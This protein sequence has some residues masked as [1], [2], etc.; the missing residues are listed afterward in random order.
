MGKAI[1]GI[2]A[3]YH[4]S[5]AALLV[6]GNISAAIQQERVSRKK[7]DASF[8]L[9]AI[10]QILTE[11]SVG[12][13]ELSAIVFY[14][15][16]FLKFERILETIHMEAP[17]GWAQF[18]AAM[19]EWIDKKLFIKKHIQ[20][21]LSVLGKVSC[22][23]LFSEHHLSH[24]ASAFYPSPFSES[25]IL[26]IDGVGEWATTTIGYGA[27][28]TISILE[29]I[30]FPHSLGLLYAAFTHYCGFKINSGEYKL[31]GLAPY[32]NRSA[33]QTQDW[34]TK[35]TSE[36]IDVKSDGSFALNLDYFR[37]TRDLEMTD[38]R[39]WE[40]LFRVSRRVEGSPITQEHCNLAAA[41]QE[42]TE[43][44]LVRLAQTARSITNSRNLTMAGGV[45]LNC[46][47]NGKLLREKIFDSIW[48]QPAAGDAGGA[49]GAAF[50]GWHILQ[51]KPREVLETDSMKGAFLG[52]TFSDNKVRCALTMQNATFEYFDKFD[53]LVSIVATALAEDCVVGWFQDRMEFGPRALGNRSILADA[54]SPFMQRRLNKDIKFREDFRP[55]APAV[56]EEDKEKYFAD[57]VPSPYMLFNFMVH[58]HERLSNVPDN[59]DGEGW[60]ERLMKRR[61][62]IPSVTH[63]DF[64]A[65]VQSVSRNGHPKFWALLNAFKKITGCSVLINTSFNVRGE[66]IVHTPEEAFKCFMIS[67]MDVLVVGNFLLRKEEQPHLAETTRRAWSDSIGTD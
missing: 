16:P 37:F 24:A 12:I 34:K 6:D 40:K 5:A 38:D 51:G 45:A 66:P 46:T 53:D 33:R 67:D 10:K 15:K 18:V 11:S 35:I 29:E 31:M 20:K 47:A 7:N 21:E 60:K 59:S 27:N 36:L 23:I 4:D 13:H 8:P 44:I 64:S 2:S 14:D 56:L 58:P 1:L 39:K 41:I 9:E 52:T 25:A 48:I 49:L 43:E 65:R 50:A 26:T 30:H 17:R 63:V 61:S 32:G 42:V 54:R 62:T 55:F 22:P 28:N 19:P 57:A 3:Y